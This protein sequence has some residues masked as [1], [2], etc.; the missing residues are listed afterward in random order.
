[1]RVVGSFRNYAGSIVFKVERPNP[2]SAIA[3]ALCESMEARGYVLVDT[4]LSG[5][6][7]TEYWKFS[8]KEPQWQRNQGH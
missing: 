7:P 8:K 6:R 2:R 5:D 1:M 3:R 4:C